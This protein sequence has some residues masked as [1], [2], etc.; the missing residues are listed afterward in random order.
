MHVSLPPIRL[1]PGQH[2][3]PSL[4]LWLQLV[5]WSQALFWGGWWVGFRWLPEAL[6]RGRTVAGALPI[7]H[8]PPVFRTLAIF[9]WNLGVLLFIGLVA[10]QVQVRRWPTGFVVVQVL[11]AMYG[12][13]LG[14]N[15]FAAPLPARPAPSLALLVQRAG[16]WELSAYTLAAMATASLGRARQ[17]SWFSGPAEKL[18]PSALRPGQR[19]LLAL[20]VTL[21]LAGAVREVITW[22]AAA[23]CD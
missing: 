22:C 10:N 2:L 21:L 12:L 6:L 13:T 9:G 1:R 4:P 8:L 20:S 14:T 11:W 7:D 3:T 15:S 16:I 18:T 5:A 23:G 19:L 17:H